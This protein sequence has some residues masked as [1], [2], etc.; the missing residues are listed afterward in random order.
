[1]ISAFVGNG[2]ILLCG[3]VCRGGFRGERHALQG[4]GQS[5]RNQRHQG[6][7]VKRRRP[8]SEFFE[9]Q[10]GEASAD[11]TRQATRDCPVRNL[12]IGAD[13]VRCVRS[14]PIHIHG[15]PTSRPD[16]YRTL[17]RNQ[18]RAKRFRVGDPS[19]SSLAWT[20]PPRSCRYANK[21][22]ASVHHR[23]ELLE[24][25]YPAAIWNEPHCTKRSVL[26]AHNYARIIMLGH[27]MAR[28]LVPCATQF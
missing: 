18:Y 6:T 19:R 21:A 24:D 15:L 14:R 11:S 20:M 1:M 3:G 25:Y 7:A 13:S 17:G 4:E 12:R 10:R 2:D 16:D 8:A 28:R 23:F 22:R 27:E 26:G 5:A 9:K